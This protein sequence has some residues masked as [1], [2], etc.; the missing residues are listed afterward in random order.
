M[1]WV[2]LSIFIVRHITQASLLLQKFW[3]PS[4]GEREKFSLLQAGMHF[5]AEICWCAQSAAVADFRGG[6]WQEFSLLRLFN[7]LELSSC[8]SSDSSPADSSVCGVP[9]PFEI[10]LL[11][12]K[13][14]GELLHWE[15]SQQSPC[16]GACPRRW[17]PRWMRQ[18]KLS[19]ELPP[20]IASSVT[21]L[22][23][24]SPLYD[25]DLLT[26]L[27]IRTGLT[28]DSGTT[29][30]CPPAGEM[31][32]CTLLW[33]Q[34]SGVWFL[35]HKLVWKAVTWILTVL[36]FSVA[37]SSASSFDAR[38]RSRTT[39]CL[40]LQFWGHKWYPSFSQM[41]MEIYQGNI[42]LAGT[43]RLINGTDWEST[44]SN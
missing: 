13:L 39:S 12:S 26:F 17:V 19:S 1:F 8:L 5:V 37:E 18:S 27:L 22:T 42:D 31:H 25:F 11:L 38:L 43:L 9:F 36:F 3:G 6:F 24:T 10:S 2:L 41:K 32:L 21:F 30:S 15:R 28:I 44:F 20:L 14:H 7:R 29:D 33:W 23:G 4:I 16:A 40:L 34:K 35:Q